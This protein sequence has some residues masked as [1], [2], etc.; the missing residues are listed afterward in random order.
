MTYLN[1]DGSPADLCGNAV[2]LFDATGVGARHPGNAAG[3]EF[4]M[5]TDAGILGI[6]LLEGPG[7]GPPA[8]E[9]RASATAIS[10]G[11]WRTLDRIC[12]GW[13]ASSR[14]SGG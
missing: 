14:R 7:S 5:E 1:S 12:D 13:G 8:G 3:K 11:A 6:R 9:R 2:A 10:A 4:R